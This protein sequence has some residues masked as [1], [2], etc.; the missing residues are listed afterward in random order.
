MNKFGLLSMLSALALMAGVARA[1]HSDPEG[2]VGRLHYEA[3]LLEQVVNN[4]YLNYN[5]KRSVMAFAGSVNR[6]EQCVSSGAR[7]LLHDHTDEVGCPSQCLY[8]LQYARS[9]FAQ[10]SRYLNDTQWD[11][12]QVYNQWA[13]TYQV[14]NAIPVSGPGTSGSRCVASDRGWEEH[15]RGHEGFGR[16]IYEAQRA[17]LGECQRFHGS[18]VIRSCQ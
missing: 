16:T 5:V 3:E 4:S 14:L 13:R 8:Q 9:L 10:V 7:S 17:A 1:D 11:F 15:G 12:P 6:L 2:S 18:C